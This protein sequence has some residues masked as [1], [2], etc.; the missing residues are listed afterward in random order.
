MVEVEQTKKVWLTVS[1]SDLTEGRGS[2]I[3]LA[4]CDTPETARRMGSRKY[5]MGTDCPIEESQAVKI[6]GR[7]YVR[8]N[9][10]PENEVDKKF[11]LSR[12]KAEEALKNRD[13]VIERAAALG[14]SAE[15]LEI[16]RGKEFK[17]LLT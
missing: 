15:D 11:R 4:V 9:I 5:V 2:Q 13:A 10:T 8:G 14:L 1:N 12:E 7:W 3:I 16:L 6:D 17:D